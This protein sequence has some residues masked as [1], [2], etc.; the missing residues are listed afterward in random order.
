PPWAP[1]PTRPGPTTSPSSS[2]GTP[3]RPPPAMNTPT[4]IRLLPTRLIGRRVYLFDSVVS[5][6]DVASGLALD[7]ENSGTVVIAAHQSAGRGQYGRAW[8]S[9]PGTSLLMS[10]LLFPPAELRRPV[11]LTA[12]AAVGIAEAIRTL[13]GAQARL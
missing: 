12:W 2:A 10:I 7:P 11:V 5:T 9:R 3:A 4:E 13:T 8:L 6:N 1:R